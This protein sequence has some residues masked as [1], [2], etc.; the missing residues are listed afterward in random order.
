MKIAAVTMVRDEADIIGAVLAHML[1]EGVDQL[2]VVDDGSTDDTPD[3]L[4]EFEKGA[5]IVVH[6]RDDPV[7]PQ[8]QVMNDLC[9]EAATAGADWV[10]PFDADEF[11]LAP[12]STFA[13]V[14]GAADAKGARKIYGQVLHHLDWERRFKTSHLPK[15]AFRYS[16]NAH[17]AIGNHDVNLTGSADGF[18][19][20]HVPYRSLEQ[21]T[22]KTRTAIARH[23][24]DVLERMGGW[25]WE[26]RDGLDDEAAKKEW[27]RYCSPEVVTDPIPYTK[28]EG[29]FAQ[30]T[31]IIIPLMRA[32]RSA[33]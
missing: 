32:T 3:I 5:G 15:V 10:I 29:L 20:R 25:Y 24:R 23:P 6:R 9:K 4:A 19:I 22:R 27:D 1:D 11:W 18:V 14:V 2:F 12:G 31:A 7:W 16:P 28:P 33:L 17:L 21:F 26:Y 8:A 30:T 13:E